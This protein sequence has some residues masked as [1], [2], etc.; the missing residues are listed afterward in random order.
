MHP[1]KCLHIFISQHYIACLCLPVVCTYLP[2]ICGVC[3]GYIAPE[4]IAVYQYS[5]ASDL[6]QVPNRSAY[7]CTCTCLSYYLRHKFHV[8]ILS[9]LSAAEHHMTDCSVCAVYLHVDI[10]TLSTLYRPDVHCTLYSVAC[11][12]SIRKITNRS[13]RGLTTP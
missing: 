6:W 1:L 4:S 9:Y 5:S 13:H 10:S 12:P 8:S 7:A 2:C 11:Y 3:A